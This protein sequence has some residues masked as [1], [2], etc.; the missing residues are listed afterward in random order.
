MGS[1]DRFKALVMVWLSFSF[2]V[3]LTLLN[4]HRISSE[5]LVLAVILAFVVLS[6]TA[7]LADE[8]F[9]DWLLQRYWNPQSRLNGT[10]KPANH[11]PLSDDD[12]TQTPPH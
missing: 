4:D 5:E 8:R 7:A 11:A 10:R 3:A 2:I 9:V 6:T 12:R 1:G